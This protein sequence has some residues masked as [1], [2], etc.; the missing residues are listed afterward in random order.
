MLNDKDFGQ[1]LYDRLPEIYHKRDSEEGID[2][3][4]LR[5]LQTL[6]EGGITTLF[7]EMLELY[8]ILQ[9]DKMPSEVVPLVGQL[10]GYEYR[11]DLEEDIQRKIIQNLI[12]LY[13]RKGTKSVLNFIAREFTKFDTK[14]VETEYR[15]FKTW[16]PNP[17]HVPTSEYT[18]SRTLGVNSPD[19]NTHHLVS[20]DGKYDGHS[21][22]IV[23]D[24]SEERITLLNNLLS[25]F[26]PVYCKLFLQ[27]KGTSNVESFEESVSIT[28][29]DNS[30]RL[31][32]NNIENV[33]VLEELSKLKMNDFS[34]D[35]SNLTSNEIGLN[36][37]NIETYSYD[38]DIITNEDCSNKIH[39]S[40]KENAKL[41]MVQHNTDSTPEVDLEP[42]EPL[43]NL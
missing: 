41:K 22:I 31:K 4:L 7:N 19:E 36:V 24:S 17:K 34:F 9:V 8:D 20:V 1:Y 39:E 21:I 11:D 2:F 18:E 26:L 33:Q 13:K 10:L 40:S 35:V 30:V 5:F 15:I 43:N 16:S 12:E 29:D 25:D 23:F 3:A 32:L 37:N 27:V 38:I 6:N 28:T 42:S 14:V